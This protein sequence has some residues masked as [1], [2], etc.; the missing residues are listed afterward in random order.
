MIVNVNLGENQAR[1]ELTPA[2][3]IEAELLDSKRVLIY[4]A[5]FSKLCDVVI[6]MP[7]VLVQ[8]LIESLQQLLEATAEL[9]GPVC[10][11]CG[12]E[13]GDPFVADYGGFC[14]ERCMK[15]YE[16][17]YHDESIRQGRETSARK[18]L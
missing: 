4:M 18:Q 11:A 3:S 5:D 9:E 10:P 7:R 1:I 16:G 8:P 15:E 14:S 17:R 12:N 6:G 2:D 13:R